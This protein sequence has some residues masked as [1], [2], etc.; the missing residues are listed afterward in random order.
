M[1]QNDP[2][3]S[4]AIVAAVADNGVIGRDNALP[5]A[6]PDD[7]RHF[8]KLTMGKPMLMGRKTF[9]SIGRPLPGRTSLVMTRN[10]AWRADGVEVV[11]TIDEAL[12]FAAALGKDLMVIGG[13]EIYAAALPVAA[14]LHLTQ[15]HSAVDGDTRFP[16][17]DMRQWQEVDREDRPAGEASP[18]SYSFVTLRRRAVGETVP[19][20][21]ETRRDRALGTRYVD[22]FEAVV[23]GGE[24]S[25]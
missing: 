11:G 9:E 7:L 16:P 5:W 19:K 15:I 17:I 22:G 23:P 14:R 13:R 3:H 12:A 21:V 24:L 6:L 4:A 25:Q 1:S 10:P 8:R 18:W 20:L 2:K